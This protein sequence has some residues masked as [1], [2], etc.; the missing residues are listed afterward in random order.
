MVA[1]I[2]Y[3]SVYSHVICICDSTETEN[4]STL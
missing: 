2:E 1:F 4:V 3:N